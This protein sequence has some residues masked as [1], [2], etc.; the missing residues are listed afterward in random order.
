MIVNYI[1]GYNCS[2]FGKVRKR[3]FLSLNNNYKQSLKLR[4]VSKKTD[5][6][7]FLL[8]SCNYKR[9]SPSTS[10]VKLVQRRIAFI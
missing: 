1:Y 2:S 10:I 7:V 8:N 9:R 3:P 6:S 4:R 5:K